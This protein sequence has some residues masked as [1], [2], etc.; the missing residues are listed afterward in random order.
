MTDD[1]IQQTQALQGMDLAQV[2]AKYQEVFGEEPLSRNR[3]VLLGQI[4]RRLHES[5][6]RAQREQQQPSGAKPAG[7]VITRIHELRHASL[8]DLRAEHEKVFGAPS[9]SRNRKALFV[10]I[11]KRVQEDA[12]RSKPEG[13][14][15]KPTLVAKFEK[16]RR[17]KNATK[18]AGREKKAGAK[19]GTRSRAKP[20]G[21]RDE[22]LPKVGSV[23]ER[24]YKG[25]KLLVRV[26][27]DGFEYQGKPYRS[28]SALA[29]VITGAKAMNGYLFFRLGDYAK[30]EKAGA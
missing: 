17:S 3:K 22:R 7:D 18:A 16:K 1:L 26:L 2:Q 27:D 25:K 29:M 10:K 4:K 19:S 24:I 11:A 9:K 8:E 5:D 20:V 30:K 15:P 21:A 28:L 23:I 13:G 14:V 12:L 6:M